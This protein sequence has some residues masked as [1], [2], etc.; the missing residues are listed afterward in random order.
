MSLRLYH[1][2]TAHPQRLKELFFILLRSHSDPK[3]LLLR[4]S[5]SLDVSSVF[6]AFYTALSRRCQLD[7][8]NL[9]KGCCTIASD[10]V[11]S[12]LMEMTM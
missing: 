9:N 10:I 3:E 12:S 7:H 1:S 5:H 4:P 2:L 11:L 8:K 6:I